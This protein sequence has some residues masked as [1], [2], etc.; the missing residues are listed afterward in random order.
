M[1]LQDA[2]DQSTSPLHHRGRNAPQWCANQGREIGLGMRVLQASARHGNTPRL[3][4]N[5]QVSGSSPLVGSSFFLQIPQKQKAPDIDIGG[6]G[7]S[8]AA[9]E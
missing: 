2:L 8:R 6:F 7:S 9:V 3:P 4:R 1:F 5:E